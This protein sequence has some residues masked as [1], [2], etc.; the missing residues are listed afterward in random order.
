MFCLESWRTTLP[1]HAEK[2]VKYLGRVMEWGAGDS[3]D[4]VVKKV[5]ALWRGLCGPKEPEVLGRYSSEE[6]A[7]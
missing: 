1:G 3:K 2:L 7:V 5:G 6:Q 4:R